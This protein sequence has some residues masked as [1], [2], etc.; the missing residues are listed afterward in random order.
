MLKYFVAILLVTNW[1][2]SVSY[3]N[4]EFSKN[5]CLQS[6]QFFIDQA[7]SEILGCK[8]FGIDQPAYQKTITTFNLQKSLGYIS[9]ILSVLEIGKTIKNYMVYQKW[10][11]DISYAE[12]VVC[13]S[14][15]LLLEEQIAY[16]QD[17]LHK[18]SHATFPEQICARLALVRSMLPMPYC[19]IMHT[20]AQKY[21]KAN[22][23][24]QGHLIWHE[25]D[26]ASLH[27][28][29]FY[30]R[31][32]Q[33]FKALACS[34]K[35]K[36]SFCK[37]THVADVVKKTENAYNQTLLDM[38][39]AGIDQN[40]PLLKKLCRS[41]HDRLIERLYQY[42]LD[43][44]IKK[45][46]FSHET[47]EYDSVKCDTVVLCQKSQDD[48][49][50]QIL[51]EWYVQDMMRWLCPFQRHKKTVQ[52]FMYK[53]IPEDQFLD[54]PLNSDYRFTLLRA[55]FD[56]IYAQQELHADVFNEL[57]LPNGILKKYTNHVWL[58]NKTDKLWKLDPVMLK[59]INFVLAICEKED[60]EMTQRIAKQLLHY[61]FCICEDNDSEKIVWCKKKIV[62]LYEALSYKRYD[63]KLLEP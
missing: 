15:L 22:F 3:E 57:F 5:E 46:Y 49:E 24:E 53:I 32:P 31:I 9:S 26:N 30:K 18:S 43:Q 27:Y 12:F 38:V 40:F 37:C 39:Y 4:Y 59:T 33:D 7:P 21:M 35:K 16:I 11:K 29:K 25:Q 48:Y 19:Q 62:V 58:Q 34:A 1:S 61:V 56:K 42:Y 60:D 8:I 20:C 52:N 54:L 44:K 6:D 13:F 63:L 50:K 10:L 51:Q 36:L 45:N 2:I 14:Y 55:F 47:D 17:L 23:D 28:K 41:Y